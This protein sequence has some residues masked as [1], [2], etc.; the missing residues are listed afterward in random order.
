MSKD[1]EERRKNRQDDFEDSIGA[2]ADFRVNMLQMTSELIPNYSGQ[3]GTFT[4]AQWAQKIEDN[5]Q[6]FGWTP[7]QQLLV[8]RRSLTG[9][10]ALWL[11]AERPFKSWDDLKAA[12]LKEFPDSVDIKTIHETMS[13]RKKKDNES[14]LD[15]MLPMKE[16]GKRGKMP[17]YVAIKYIV[18]G[19]RDLETNKIMLYGVTTYAE[20]KEKLRIYETVRSKMEQRRRSEARSPR[21]K[22]S[23]KNRCFSCGEMNHTSAFC[24]Y[25]EKGLVF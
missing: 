3:D 11:R 23:E 24:P 19:I 1:G 6:I 16:L 4:A 20:L 13:T 9:T 17:D 5:A 18:D 12:V 22:T 15:Y 10:A 7:L 14:C 2:Q 8:A 25:K 21:Q